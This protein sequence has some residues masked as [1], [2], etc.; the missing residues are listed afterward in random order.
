VGHSARG[1]PRTPGRALEAL[2][3]DRDLLREVDRYLEA[4][5]LFRE[6]HDP[7]WHAEAAPSSIVR[8]VREWLEPCE[9]RVS[10][11]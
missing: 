8:R 10:D 3:D 6:R 1:E 5:A 9:P 11:A 2:G 4:V 7:T